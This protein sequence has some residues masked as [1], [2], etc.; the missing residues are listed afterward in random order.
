MKAPLPRSLDPV[1]G[2]LLPGYLLSLSHRIGIPPGDLAHQCGLL[3]AN[4]ILT[5]P[6]VR[7]DA[8]QARQ[9]ATICRL[10]TAEV[11]GLTLA[12][13]APGYSPLGTIYLGQRQSP[14][15]MGNSGWVFT[16]F[17]RYCPDCLSDTADLPDGPIW[18]GS[19]RFPHTLI[20]PDHNRHLAWRRPACEAPAFSNGYRT[21]GKWRP[22]Q[23]I[24][25]PRI[26][27]HPRRC[28]HRVAGGWGTPCAAD[29]DR[30]LV[31]GTA[32]SATRST[33]T[34]A[35]RLSRRGRP[36]DRHREPGEAGLPAKASPHSGRRANAPAPAPSAQHLRERILSN[37][38]G[39]RIRLCPTVPATVEAWT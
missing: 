14:L 1:A 9:I 30:T 18:Q 26:R 11:H 12:G 6:L 19:W 20:C 32:P 28:R 2:E 22:S 13:Q 35:T 8:D 3:Q 5:Q 24:P 38:V 33:R 27:L 25:G 17:S 7:L 37:K 29:L 15:D 36:R 4:R 34:A 10:E 31:T 39:R 16:T 21:E 23:L